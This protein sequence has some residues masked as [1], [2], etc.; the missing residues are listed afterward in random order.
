M[1]GMN[2]TKDLALT[3]ENQYATLP[4]DSLA[5]DNL[6]I[7]IQNIRLAIEELSS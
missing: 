3:I 4:P 2:E 7:L 1:M 6:D 5:S